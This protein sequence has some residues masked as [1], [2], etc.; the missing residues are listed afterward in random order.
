MQRRGTA[1]LGHKFASARALA[2]RNGPLN[3]RAR[4]KANDCRW[5]TSA[6]LVLSDLESWFIPLWVDRQDMTVPRHLGYIQQ[7]PRSAHPDSRHDGDKAI[8]V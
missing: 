4:T 1:G 6:L 7:F 2:G 3:G 5:P 8:A